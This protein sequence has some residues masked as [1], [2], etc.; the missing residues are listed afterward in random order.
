MNAHIKIVMLLPS[1]LM[2]AFI[3][4]QELS[5]DE[6]LRAAR[7]N[8]PV[9]KKYDLITKSTE[10]TL[11]NISKA[12]WPQLSINGQ[13]TYQNEVTK[14]P[15]SMP[16]VKELS[17]DQYRLQAE[18]SQLI[19]DGGAVQAQKDI[20]RATE[21]AQLQN[22]EVT[23]QSVKD[24]VTE[25]YFGIL[26]L[27]E[28]YA[29]YLL[30]RQ[31]L[32]ASLKKAEAAYA[33]GVSFK[34]NMNELKAEIINANMG[35]VEI[36]SNQKA[37]KNMLALLTGKTINDNTSFKTPDI[38]VIPPSIQRPEIQL[39]DLQKN[40]YDA[41]R[42][43][44]QADW[45][46]K[47]SAF[48]QGGYGR[49]GLNM[50]NNEFAP[51]AIGGIRLQFPLYNIYGWKNNLRQLEINKQTLET[52][53]ETFLLNTNIS[54][55][56]YQQEISTYKILMQQDDELIA[57]RQSI[58]QAAQ[59]QLDNQVITVSEYINKLNAEYLARQMKNMHQLQLLQATYN[60]INTNGN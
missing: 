23:L 35:A 8:Y 58:T 21:A 50:L 53:K 37:Y 56:K 43:K 15:V 30:R 41:Q 25:I 45:F 32:D 4:A 51:L 46:P 39:F 20:T 24:R 29:Q 11:Q 54:L 2:T 55:Q 1:F 27:N 49:P 52:D 28:Q 14:I 44:L 42:K 3:H 59:A 16:G 57:L 31:S 40:V 33:N 47:I 13:A 22:I 7:E 17:K 19:Y 6:A 12:Y 5:L 38:P 18:V 36:Q 10:Y 26:L 48:A 9:I 34:S 60:Y